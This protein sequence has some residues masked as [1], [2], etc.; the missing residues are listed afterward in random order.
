MQRVNR[1]SAGYSKIDHL[2]LVVKDL[3]KT[4]E[5]LTS[6]GLGPCTPPKDYKGEGK[7][8]ISHIMIGD[9]DLEIE[10]PIKDYEDMQDLIDK[11]GG[12]IDHVAFV[13][14][15]LE[16]E[17]TKL[18]QKGAKHVSSALGESGPRA[19]MFK[20]DDLSGILIQISKSKQ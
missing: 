3:N 18:I 16:K 8:L 14:D 20:I 10:Q 4:I 5:F 7:L 15:D 6:L 9:I 1:K 17:K 11:R 19:H 2:G 12:G 13:V